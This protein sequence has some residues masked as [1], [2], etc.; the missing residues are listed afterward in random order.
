MSSSPFEKYRTH[1]QASGP[2][3]EWTDIEIWEGFQDLMSDL[4]W[5]SPDRIGLRQAIVLDDTDAVQQICG[6]WLEVWSES[7]DSDGDLKSCY[8]IQGLRAAHIYMWL[9]AHVPGIPF[10]A[11]RNDQLGCLDHA[12][13]EAIQMLINLDKRGRCPSCG[14]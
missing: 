13:Q 10:E 7:W 3:V 5:G 4:V 1:D 11:N 8:G 14:R 9:Y 6:N 12:V 2:V